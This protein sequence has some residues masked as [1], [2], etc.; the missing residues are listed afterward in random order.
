MDNV[1][2]A[3]FRPLNDFLLGAARFQ[4]PNVKDLEKWANRVI[5]NLLYYQTNYFVVLIAV[6]LLVG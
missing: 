1:E 5:N 2:L 4:V 6:F 3:P